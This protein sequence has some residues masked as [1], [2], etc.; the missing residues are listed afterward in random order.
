MAGLKWKIFIWWSR[1]GTETFL[2]WNVLQTDQIKIQ[3]EPDRLEIGEL[4]LAQ[5]V[6]KFIIYEDQTINV[7]KVIKT[8]TDSKS[9]T[10]PSVSAESTTLKPIFFGYWFIDLSSVTAKMEFADLSLTPQFGTMNSRA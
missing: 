9:K 1:R 6:G 5:L 4:K 8:D 3:L 10:V 7:L 2:G